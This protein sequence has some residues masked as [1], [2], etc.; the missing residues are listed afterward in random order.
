MDFFVPSERLHPWVFS[1]RASVCVRLLH[2]SEIG[3]AQRGK[4][5]RTIGWHFKM[6]FAGV[7]PGRW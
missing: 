3:S 2:R 6:P 4:N 5:D 1:P 7:G